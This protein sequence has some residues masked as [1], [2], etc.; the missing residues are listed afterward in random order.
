[1]NMQ[2]SHEQL[3]DILSLTYKLMGATASEDVL[4]ELLVSLLSIFDVEGSS[5][6]LINDP[7]THLNFFLQAGESKSPGFSVSIGKGIAGHVAING[8]PIRVQNAEKDHRFF[9][10][11]DQRTGFQTRSILYRMP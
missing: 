6:A 1:M 7:K 8:L 9:K 10:G 2:I 11:V 5:I 4:E 3:K